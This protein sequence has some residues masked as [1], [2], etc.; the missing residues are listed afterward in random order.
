L[1]RL[2]TI[3]F[4][5]TSLRFQAS[6]LIRCALRPV[7]APMKIGAQLDTFRELPAYM[8]SALARSRSDKPI[9][10]ESAYARSPRRD[11][12]D[13]IIYF[14][15]GSVKLESLKSLAP[16]A[17]RT[18]QTPLLDSAALCLVQSFHKISVPRSSTT[19]NCGRP[20][21]LRLK[22]FWFTLTPSRNRPPRPA[23]AGFPPT[24]ARAR[25]KPRAIPIRPRS[26]VAC[27]PRS[28]ARIPAR[29]SR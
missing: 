1:R 17:V 21:D 25:S 23:R 4:T 22:R 5:E 9:H 11:P 3:I 26:R 15:V 28:V 12:Q 27:R 20:A 6:H 19:S 8:L 7:R 29:Y 2:K 16:L 10:G 18:S 13:P 14:T 24:P